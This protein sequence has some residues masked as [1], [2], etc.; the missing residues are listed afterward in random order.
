MIGT[1]GTCC[2]YETYLKNNLEYLKTCVSFELTT[3]G[4]K[5]KILNNVTTIYSW[6]YRAEATLMTGGKDIVDKAG[7]TFVFQKIND[8]WKVVY[9]HESS[10]P[11]IRKSSI[12]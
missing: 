2:D 4:E 12:S 11:P 5:I 3:L 7:A 10:V 1:D 6:A 9:Y 8:L